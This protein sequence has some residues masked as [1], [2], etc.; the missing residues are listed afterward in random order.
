MSLDDVDSV[1]LVNYNYEID[2]RAFIYSEF[3]KLNIIGG[4]PV[5]NESAFSSC[6]DLKLISF[7]D[8][9]I[10]IGEYA[11]L[12][13]GKN[14]DVV[15][16]NCTGYVDKRAFQYGDFMSLAINNK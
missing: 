9:N 11:F 16:S 3:T 2:E 8:C 1:T 14:A 13:C 10:K 4:S 12:S 5:I 7:E 15:F 6:E